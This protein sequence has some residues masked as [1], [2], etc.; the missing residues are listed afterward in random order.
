MPNTE[1]EKTFIRDGF[2]WLGYLLMASACFVI[3]CFGPA[4]PFLRSELH[5]SY[6]IG[7]LHFS[8][9]AIG[10][11]IA[12]TIGDQW[13]RKLGRVTTIWTCC[14]GLCSAI[15]ILIVATHPAITIFG[16]LLG[17]LSGSIMGQTVNTIMS[18]R[19]GTERALGITEANI[20]ASISCFLAPLAV[21]TAV[22]IGLGWRY[23]IAIPLISFS[24][25]FLIFFRKSLPA[26]DPVGLAN[27][28]S[29]R[30]P[31]AYWAY[32][33]VIALNVACEWSMIFWS[34]DFLEKVG[35][36]DRTDASACVSAFVGAMLIG[37]LI[38]R[39]LAERY[40][41]HKL[42]PVAAMI[43]I[44]GFMIFWL[45][46]SAPINVAGLFLTGLGIANFYP[47]TLAAAI[48][49]VPDRA[50]VA[51]AR[52]SLGTGSA[53]LIAPLLLGMVADSSGIFIA[54]GVIA[55]LLTT[56]AAM[57]FLANWLAHRHAALAASETLT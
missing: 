23:A 13:M 22:R 55:V 5:L 47:L 50:G 9:W 8:A 26:C 1:N 29:G 12:G 25:L 38:G 34:A 31:I 37:R 45:G 14:L 49:V 33:T 20:I 19:F 10:S 2:T 35:R 42:L 43:A 53:I 7:A 11:L 56:C 32:W 41:I 52:M 21:S 48:G 3:S 4:M 51:T 57:V 18:D 28:S 36:L 17:G 24:I 54:Y 6:T 15:V 27:V 39:R 46:R 16:A 44:G 40:D 30:L